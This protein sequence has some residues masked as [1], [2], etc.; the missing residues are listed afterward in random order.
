VDYSR[1]NAETVAW[2]VQNAANLLQGELDQVRSLND[3]AAQLAGFSGVV[4]AILGSLA[5]DGFATKLGSVG[6]SVF[7]AFYFGSAFLLA[8]TILWLV[9]LVHRPRR[10]VAV[11][12]EE[13]RTYFTDERLLEAEPWALQ[14]R[15]MRTI[16]PAAVWAKKGAAQME[17]RIGVG[18]GLFAGGLTLFL[19]AVITL[20]VGS[21]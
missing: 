3:K 19:G 1:I 16:Y 10:R 21:P 14:I 8:A 9:L 4:L 12:P 17:A 15:T 5:S 13:I 11:D 18:A 20:G 2:A 7:A 6:E